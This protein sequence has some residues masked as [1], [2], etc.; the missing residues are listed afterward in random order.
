M[1]GRGYLTVWQAS[2]TSRER[3]AIPSQ[4][5][6]ISVRLHDRV[7]EYW[8]ATVSLS[9]TS[10]GYTGTLNAPQE[11]RGPPLTPE[12]RKSLPRNEMNLCVLSA[13]VL[14]LPEY[15]RR[16]RDT[17]PS[18][19]AFEGFNSFKV[20]PPMT[21]AADRATGTLV[22]FAIIVLTGFGDLGLTVTLAGAVSFSDG[23]AS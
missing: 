5:K 13:D 22:T 6:A 3:K 11:P 4:R 23:V 10:E 1:A 16:P 21:P 14:S 18:F 15:C 7:I 8:I 20:S 17:N 19:Y 12:N 2:R 9:A